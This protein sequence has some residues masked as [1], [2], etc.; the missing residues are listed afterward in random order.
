M[1]ETTRKICSGS[2]RSL[3]CGWLVLS[4]VALIASFSAQAQIGGSATIQGNVSDPTGTVIVGA[5]VR[6]K[7]LKT[8]AVLTRSTDKDG[9][10]VLSPMDVGDYIVA[11]DAKGF[12]KLLRENV[13]VD[14]MQVL[15][16]N[17][18]LQ[19]GSTNLTVT[20]TPEMNSSQLA[21]LRFPRSRS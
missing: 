16:L 12:E 3:G 8:G 10:F 1:I 2:L 11:A 20:V 17:L 6:A 15:G 21:N 13:H 19:V 5:K 9:F 14:G 4:V 18:T 7:S